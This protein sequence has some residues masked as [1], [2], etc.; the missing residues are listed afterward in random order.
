MKRTEQSLIEAFSRNVTVWFIAA[1][2]VFAVISR[3]ELRG[4]QSGDMHRYLLPWYQEILQ[5]GGLEALGQQVGNYGIPYQTIIA[6]LTYL[7]LSAITAY[8][9]ISCCFDVLLAAVC[10]L[11]IREVS[12]TVKK[13]TLAILFALVLMS[14]IVILNSAVWGQCD[15]IYTFFCLLSLLLFLKEKDLW[16]IV[17]YGAAFAFKLQAVFLLPVIGLIYLKEKGFLF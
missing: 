13:N 11:I 6:L 16:G 3:F 15:S 9:L 1:V 7:P 12:D 8:K 4:F 14:P 10:V 5:L 2:M 17:A